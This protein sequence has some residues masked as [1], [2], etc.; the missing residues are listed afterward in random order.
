MPRL[1]TGF[2]V[3]PDVAFELSMLRG[4][5]SGARWID[6]DNYHVTLRFLGDIDGATARDFAW[7]LDEVQGEPIEV[8]IDALDSF[9]GDKPRA[10]LARV[11]LSRDLADLQYEHEKL[12]RRVGLPPEQRKFIPHVT[13]ARMRQA[14]AHGVAAWLG[15]RALFRSI[16]FTAQRFVLF[17]SRESTGGGPYLVEA[18]YPLGYSDDLVAHTA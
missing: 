8:T 9:G 2:E 10:L 13:L 17:S 16:T 14:S 11:K 18:Q 12:A 6:P 7:G 5:V 1:F 15:A 3:P 4:G